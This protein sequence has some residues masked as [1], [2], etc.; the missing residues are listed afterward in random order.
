MR[1]L[2]LGLLEEHLVKLD[3]GAL[4]PAL[5]SIILSLLPGLEEETGEDFDRTLSLVDKMKILVRDHHTSDVKSDSSAGDDFFWQCFF[6]ASITGSTRRQGALAYLVR[7]LPKLGGLKRRTSVKNHRDA[8]DGQNAEQLSPEAQAVMS[9]EPGLLVRCFASGLADP[10]ILIQRGFLDLLVTHVPLDSPILQRKVNAKD[11]ELLV[12]AAVG[13]VIRRDMSLNRR[14]WAWLLGPEP[15]ADMD[16]ANEAESA[17]EEAKVSS[18]V[19]YFRKYGFD[20]LR[21]FILGMIENRKPSPSERA[22]PFRLCL[23]LMDRWEVG[24]LLITDIFVPAM[25]SAYNY[26]QIGGKEETEEV[27]RSASIFF[28]GVESG[29]IWGELIQLIATALSNA[30]HADALDQLNL[31]QFIIIKF[32][33]REEEMLVHH[34]PTVT[35]ALLCIV[36]QKIWQRARISNELQTLSLHIAENL[37][38]MIPERAFQQAKPSDG[39]SAGAMLLTSDKIENLVRSVRHF[40][41]QER[42]NLGISKPPISSRDIGP[43]LLGIIQSLLNQALGSLENQSLFEELSKIMSTIVLKMR[44]SSVLEHLNLFP[45]FRIVL[46]DASADPQELTAPFSV[47]SSMSGL[48]MS[49]HRAGVLKSNARKEDVKSIVVPLVNILWWHLSPYFPKHH[50]EAVRHLRQ[51]EAITAPARI[52]EAVVTSSVSDP[53]RLLDNSAKRLEA[54]RRFTVFWAHGIQLQGARGDRARGHHRSS[55][56]TLSGEPHFQ[57]DFSRILTRPLLVLIDSLANEDT[58]LYGFVSSW[59]QTLPSISEIFLVLIRGLR[60][61]NFVDRM[62]SND[63]NTR[64][65]T[66]DGDI[67]DSPECLHY[68]HQLCYIV[69]ISSEQIWITLAGATITISKKKSDES[70]VISLQAFL[71]QMSLQVLKAKEGSPGPYTSYLAPQIRRVA[72]KLLQL[73]FGGPYAS[74]LRELEIETPLLDMLIQVVEEQDT[75][76][77]PQLLD[78]IVSASKLRVHQ[79][80][81]SVRL[82]KQAR[83]S[84]IISR[85]SFQN[86]RTDDEQSTNSTVQPPSQLIESVRA[87]FSS[88]SNRFYLDEWVNFLT[89]ILVIYE[90]TIFQNLIPLVECFCKQISMVFDTL[91]LVFVKSNTTQETSPE[92]TLISLFNGLEQILARAHER[93]LAEETKTAGVKSPEQ[94]QSFFGNMVTG[95]LSPEI[96]QSRSPTANSRLAVLLS[97]QDTVRISFSIWSWAGYSQDDATLDTSS[98]A[99][100]GYTSLRMRNRARRILEHLFAAEPLECLET[101]AMIWCRSSEEQEAPPFGLLHVLD[102]SRPKNTIPAM[103]NAI[104]SRTSPSALEQTRISTLTS[105]LSEIEL[106]RFLIGYTNSIEDDAMD[107]IWSDCMTFLRDVLSNPMPHRQILPGLLEFTIVLAQKLDNTSFG[108]QRRMR[109]ELS[110]SEQQI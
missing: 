57:Q 105:E 33:V 50:V 1:P 52:I 81:Q 100:F 92:P 75:D 78:I 67:D 88:R 44:N 13:V 10:Q 110:V 93:L 70:E 2:Y 36:R 4:R 47:A 79:T 89:E 83:A 54:A 82:R 97:F 19:A 48:L 109:R 38:S 32:N 41:T 63:P 87:G 80:T 104:Y 37:L 11:M 68:L 103:F 60:S 46:A 71:V 73:I 64:A 9:P 21:R 85:P 8:T 86:E 39:N 84:S 98:A 3:A 76:L 59:L 66:M 58:E 5:K 56:V 17:A 102:G 24:G 91:K 34:I 25:K 35:F 15:S 106:V 77:Q 53:G 62:M 20:A 30:N 23:S 55:S 12:G 27:Q 90:D 107:E 16:G 7:K 6:L 43:L 69:K 65:D 108:D 14:L 99:T 29:L 95:I 42:G 96:T 40:Y 26:S 101:L 72:L 28:D 49:F 31:V 18:T 22:K 45:A 61:L 74:P 94:P 51:L